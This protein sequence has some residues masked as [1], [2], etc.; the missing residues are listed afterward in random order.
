VTF[1]GAGLPQLP[2]LAGDAKSYAERLFKF[3]MIGELGEVEATQA[4]VEPARFEGV[5]FPRKQRK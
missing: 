2:G 5:D 3:P 1:A 4:L